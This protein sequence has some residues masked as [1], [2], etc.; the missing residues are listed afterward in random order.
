MISTPHAEPVPIDMGDDGM[1]RVGGTRVT[2]QTVVYAFRRGATAEAIVEQY[3][4]L[5]LPD[6]YLVIGYYLQHQADVDEYV[7][8]QEALAEQVRQENERR[9]PNDPL[10]ARLLARLEQKRNVGS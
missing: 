9:I 5:S 1:I 10:R 4:V 2:L 8:T 7:R 3:P 6:V